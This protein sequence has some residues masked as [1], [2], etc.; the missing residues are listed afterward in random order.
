MIIESDD[1]SRRQ[2]EPFYDLRHLIKREGLPAQMQTRIAGKGI[3]D[4]A[5]HA[6]Q[7]F[8]GLERAKSG[9]P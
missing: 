7:L 5:E 9:L 1:R 4:I 8:G 3:A 2:R 6:D